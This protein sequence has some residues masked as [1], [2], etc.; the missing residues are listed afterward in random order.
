MTDDTRNGYWHLNVAVGLNALLVFLILLRNTRQFHFDIV[1]WIYMVSVSLGYYILAIYIVASLSY[2]ILSSFRKLAVAV[3]GA[4]I[5]AAIYYLLVDS[6]TFT[7]IK[8]HIDLFWLK[9]IASDFDAFGLSP[10]TLRSALLALIALIIVEIGIFALARQARRRTYMIAIVWVLLPLMFVVS[11][12]THA[13]AYETNDIR[14]TGLTPQLPFYL[15]VTSHRNAAR[16]A[17]VLPIG[18]KESL[19]RSNGYYGTLHYPLDTI[20]CDEIGSTRRPNVVILF[21]ESWRYD[22]M[23]DSVTPHIYS[24]AQK[25][26]VCLN[27]LCSGNSTVAGIF[28]FFYGLYPTYWP[29]VKA[30]NAI[31][32]NPVLI[33]VLIK[34]NYTFGIYAKSNFQR[35]KIKDAIFRDIPVYEN[36]AGKTKVEQDRN[37]NR[38][39]ISF[40]REQR[41]SGT[42]FMAMAFYK[43]NHAPYEYPSTD[44]V[45]RPAADQNLMDADDNTDPTEY[46]NDYR[47]ATR[48]VDSLAGDVLKELDSLGLMTNT[49]ILVTTDHGEEFNDNRTGYW[50]HGS[51]YTQYQT[52]VPL[53]FYAPGRKPRQLEQA[54]SHIDVAPTLLEEFLGCRNAIEDYSNGR[55]LFKDI[56]NMRPFVVGSYVSH[57]FIIEDDVYEINSY[58]VKGYKQGN[59]KEKASAPSRDMLREIANEM[60]RFSE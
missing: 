53:V 5:T 19:H 10:I 15:P 12:A 2:L 35:H 30:D 49:I 54:T 25:S 3:S 46:L 21:L 38:Q 14:I 56:E 27:H 34:E 33:D 26:T 44:T 39:L 48:Y 52:R 31:I 8:M 7:I 13:L 28:G 58:Y 37:M 11:Q 57:A 60:S 6:Y 22:M 18:E 32:H 41:R 16:Y 51:N 4:I 42:P 9:W 47:N 55:N 50:G 59:I 23:N 29:A 43:S 17:D 40:L 24:L 20:V 1:S 36:F 45:F